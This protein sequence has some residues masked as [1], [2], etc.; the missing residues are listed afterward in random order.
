[1][2]VLK[3]WTKGNRVL[4]AVWM[5]RMKAPGEKMSG[6]YSEGVMRKPFC[7]ENPGL[8]QRKGG[9]DWSCLKRVWGGWLWEEMW[10]SSH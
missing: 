10:E 2:K 3:K 9:A 6:T 8:L 5:I 1:M 7:L 4:Q